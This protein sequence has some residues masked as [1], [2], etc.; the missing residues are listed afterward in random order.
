MPQRMPF[1]GLDSN[2]SM[3]FPNNSVV[4]SLKFKAYK[5]IPISEFP[6][7]DFGTRG[8]LNDCD[9][10]QRVEYLSSKPYKRSYMQEADPLPSINFFVNSDSR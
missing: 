7:N 10:T 6:V 2:S 3:K 9:Q 5:D 8:A 4:T 1:Y